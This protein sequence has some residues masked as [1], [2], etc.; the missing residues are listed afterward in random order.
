[1]KLKY[2]Q[3]LSKSLHYIYE[4]LVCVASFLV[5]TFSHALL[6]LK[7]LDTKIK[8]VKKVFFLYFSVDYSHLSTKLL[9]VNWY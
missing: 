6:Y 1:M 3:F 2:C 9:Y 8:R 4:K 5:F 7:Y